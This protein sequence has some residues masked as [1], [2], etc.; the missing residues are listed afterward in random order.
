[1][2]IKKSNKLVFNLY[3]R[4]EYVVH[5]RALKEALNHGLI[6]KK[7]HRVTQFNQKAWLKAYIEMNI[8]LRTEAKDGF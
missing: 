7:V 6:F 3:D 5:I 2:K 4:I 1:M 8:K